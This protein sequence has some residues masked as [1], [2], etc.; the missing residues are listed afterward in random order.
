MDQINEH[1]KV[2][3]RIHF[4]SRAEKVFEYLNT[5]KGREKFWSESANEKNG[6]IEFIFP[7]GETWTGVILERIP[8]KRFVVEYFGGSITSFQ[9]TTD[10][11]GETDLLLQDQKVSKKWEKEVLAGWVSVLMSMKGAVDFGIDLRNHDSERTWNQGY[12]DN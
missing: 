6:K 2:E 9:L 8:N 3:W 10:E 11:D 5:A 4:K 12:C 1:I 7:G